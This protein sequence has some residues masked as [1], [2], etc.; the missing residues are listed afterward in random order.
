MNASRRSALARLLLGGCAYAALGARVALAETVTYTYDAL[1]RVI[2][3]SYSNGATVTY[4]YDPAGNRTTLTQTPPGSV[5]GFLTATPNEIL[6]GQSVS[7]AWTTNNA[8]AASINHGVGTVTPTA[9]GSVSASPSTTRTYTLTA[10]GPNGPALADAAVTVHPVPTCSL[11]ASPAT[12]TAGQTTT[13][14]WTSTGA[15]SAS[16]D[17]GVGP[18]TPVSGGSIA[19][20]PSATTTYTL[21]VNGPAGGQATDPATVTVNQPTFTET[22]QITGTGPVNLRTLANTAGYNGA[23][24]ANVT[25]E[26]GNGITITGNAGGGI[27]IDSGT[28][29]GSPYTITITLIIKTGGIVRG[30]GGLGGA[31]GNYGGGSA[32]SAG[33]DAIYCRLPMSITIQSGAQARGGGGGGGGAGSVEQGWPEPEY[34][35]GGG[36]GGGAPNG[37]GGAGDTGASNG[38][39]GTT[40][41]GGNGGAGA[42]G[43]VNGGNGGGYGANGANGQSWASPSAPGGA[44]GAA[45]YCIRKNGHTVT[46]TNNGTTSGTIG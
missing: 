22:I 18:V 16:I 30:G 4:A 14:T 43:G 8:T 1:G 29:P 32:G 23:Q 12:I 15:T 35:P 13:L 21:T 31:A 11:S 17:N 19:V 37:T 10:T 27:A 5:Q 6:V 46:V 7:L 26:V 41:G 24:N 28:W 42:N 40:S 36:G 3:A 34:R 44:G 25:F 2:V 33:G 38:A 45:G 39:S 9:G 20:T